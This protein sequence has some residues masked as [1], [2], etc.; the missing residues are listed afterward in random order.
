MWRSRLSL[1]TLLARPWQAPQT[2][3]V[4]IAGLILIMVG[5]G[6]GLEVM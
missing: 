4:I 3:S 6:V 5:R 2:I 1:H